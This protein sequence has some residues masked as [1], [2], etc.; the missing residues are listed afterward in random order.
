MQPE[1]CASPAL[2]RADEPAAPLRRVLLALDL[3][4]GRKFG[5]MEEQVLLLARA[6]RAAGGLCLPLFNGAAPPPEFAAAG[7][8]AAALDLRRFRPASLWRLL[9]LVRGRRIDVVHWNFFPALQN[10]YLWGMTL[11]APRVQHY[12]TDH[13]SRPGPA[14]RVPGGAR[15]A[16]KRLLLRRYRRVVC[17]S[18]HVLGRVEQERAWRQATTCPHYVNT[19]RFRP[20]AGVRSQVR[21]RLGV[22]ERGFVVVCV[23]QLIPAKGI[24]VAVRALTELPEA[25][26]LWVAGEGPDGPRLREL[27]EGL[28]V[29][30]RVRFLGPQKCVEPYLQA[31]DCLACPSLWE[32][33]AG[34]VNLEAQACGLPVV[35]SRVGGIP[36]YVAE[37]ETGFLFPPGEH[38]A[39]AACVRR[40]VDCPQECRSLGGAAREWAVRRFSPESR[41]GQFLDLYRAGG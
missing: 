32:E 9:R 41:L 25:V 17:V 28:G 33:A 31:A 15:L 38:R 23:A 40:L 26:H 10:A 5:S 24:D 14:R 3:E 11:L 21:G 19:D 37:G 20:D 2:G 16:L 27:A 29:A 8:P 13:I 4:P 36:E 22:P 39:L 6:F 35:A 18:R 12:F 34:L 7:L 1:T 30:G